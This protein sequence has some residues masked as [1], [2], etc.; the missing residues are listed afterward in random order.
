MEGGR[1]RA[2]ADRREER[3]Q[4]LATLSLSLPRPCTHTHPLPGLAGYSS[5]ACMQIPCH[6]DGTPGQ[7][8]PARGTAQESYMELVACS[9]S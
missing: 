4:Q 9:G 5:L 3:P 7:A 8:R 6:D 2:R 1:V